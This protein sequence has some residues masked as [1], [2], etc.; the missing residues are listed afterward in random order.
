LGRRG[1]LV[2][3][4]KKGPDYID[5]MW[6]GAAAG[7]P[8][9]NLDPYLCD[10]AELR[11]YYAAHLAGA[12]AELVEG[13]KGLHDGMSLDGSDSSAALAAVLDLPVLLVLDARGQTRG[14]APLL[15]G[16]QRFEPCARIAGVVLNRVAGARH[17]S[18]LRAAIEHY[19]DVTVIGALPETGD[20]FVSERHLGLIPFNEAHAARARI[21]GLADAVD[22]GLA[23]DARLAIP[24]TE[25]ARSSSEP[26]VGAAFPAAARPRPRRAPV[27]LGIARDRA[28][29]FYYADDLE[30]LEAAGAT[31]VPFDTLA[32]DALP[33][34]DA[35][36]IGGGFPEVLAPELEANASMRASI[37]AA[38]E[39]GMPV[40]AECGGLMYLAR[41]IR[42]RG[43]SYAMVGALPVDV[44]MHRK[45][46]GRGHV[47]LRE[48]ADFPW[49][50]LAAAGAE[51]GPSG[52]ASAR[53]EA[54]EPA[55]ERDGAPERRGHELHYSS[56]HAIDGSVRFGYRVLRGHGVDGQ[57]DGIVWRNVFAS[58]AHL[59][60]VGD[61]DWPRRFVGFAAA[62]VRARHGV[63]PGEHASGPQRPS[64]RG[65]DALQAPGPGL[66][67]GN[68]IEAMRC[69][70]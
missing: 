64:S 63:A 42:W 47:R 38:V 22:A 3:P 50:A 11:R 1:L 17:E 25:A 20:A 37:R 65:L 34:V 46:V 69:R 28:F 18:K 29:G 21:E 15:L 12:D 56:L 7:R 19:T 39:A 45:P 35:L 41:S 14:I 30:A 9:R 51:R 10:A 67:P 13:N 60:S 26:K 70:A 6:L 31:L 24:T 43:R 2:Q 68:E 8:C 4:Y 48:T 61:C 58:Y 27:R 53:A 5:P 33:P 49:Q 54:P 66:V 44:R 16:L 40:Y 23:L 62:A 36:F 55:S 57:H 52:P 32:D 59:R